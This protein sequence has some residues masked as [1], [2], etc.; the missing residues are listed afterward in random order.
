[1]CGIAGIRGAGG[2]GAE[3]A[4]QCEAAVRLLR[5]RGPDH[6]A[7]RVFSELVLGHSRLS[8]VDPSP[9]AHQP[10][11]DATGRWW[12]A[13]NGEIYNFLELRDE[14]EGLGHAFRTASDCEVALEAYKRWG[15]GCQDHFNGMWA[16]AIHDVREGTLF[17]SRDRFGIKPLYWATAGPDLAFASEMKALFPF[18]VSREPEWAQVVSRRDHW[19]SDEAEGATVFKHVHSLPA[20]HCMRV[21]AAGQRRIARWWSIGDHAVPIPERYTDRVARL[22]ELFEDAVR[23]RLQNDVDTAVAL[24]GGLDSSSV[25]G[26]ATKLLRDGAVRYATGARTRRRVAVFSVSNPGSPIDELPW[27]EAC[28]RF[29]NDEESAEIVRPEARE[30]PELMEEMVCHQEAPVW[31]PSVFALHALYRRVAAR[32]VRVILEGHGPDELLG[33]YGILVWAAIRSYLTGGRFGLAWAASRCLV[34]TMSVPQMGT[35]PALPLLAEP[36]RVLGGVRRALGSLR[37][38]PPGLL[39][40]ALPGVPKRKSTRDA[41]A[42]DGLD[43]ALYAAFTREVLP[44]FLRV[45]DRATMAYGVES[46]APFLDHRVVQYGFSLPDEDKIGRRTKRILRDAA[47]AWIPRTVAERKGKMPFAVPV[48]EW[49]RS[50]PVVEYVADVLRSDAARSSGL[51]DNRRVDACVERGVAGGFTAREARR[52][53]KALNLQLWHQRFC[54]PIRDC[55]GPTGSPPLQLS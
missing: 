52:V 36:L 21:D 49:F 17:L 39:D 2:L 32:G 35:P 14:L 34:D 12:I 13:M 55:A 5:H 11:S 8:I 24:S 54:S 31:S 7:V 23:L 46:T 25:Y 6:A 43:R 19:Q 53:W 40:D 27:I 51:L 48:N 41:N 44:G 15:E 1:V 37:R 16:L 20:G 3:R 10:L 45:F 22:R 18:G 47:A 30:L 26:A 9:G 28:L 29:W 33:G 42:F 4:T 38:P 50:A